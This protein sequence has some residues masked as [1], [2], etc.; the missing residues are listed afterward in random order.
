M[1]ST[2]AG[3]QQAFAERLLKRLIADFEQLKSAFKDPKQY[4]ANYCDDL[5]YRIELETS[6]TEMKSRINPSEKLTQTH[7]EIMNQVRLF[8]KECQC[9]LCANDIFDTD[10]IRATQGRINEI[11][12]KLNSI[13]NSAEIPPL[14]YLEFQ[15][16]SCLDNIHEKIFI[17]RGL[18]FL[19]SRELSN[20]D[21]KD[22]YVILVVFKDEFVS[23][24]LYTE[25]R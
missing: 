14:E 18:V 9:K 8:E 21:E 16:E 23:H 15:V 13:F 25:K 5:R 11:E 17:K 24:Y 3:L 22:W 7:R 1:S 20:V 2:L 4:I 12:N 6:Y 19:T 10:Y